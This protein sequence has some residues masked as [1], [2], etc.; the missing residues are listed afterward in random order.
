M[1]DENYCLSCVQGESGP[2]GVQSGHDSLGN[3]TNQSLK[4]LVCLRHSYFH[5]NKMNYYLLI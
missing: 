2:S 4:P 5:M 1:C 3:F